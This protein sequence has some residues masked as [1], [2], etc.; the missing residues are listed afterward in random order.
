M[1]TSDV[2]KRQKDEEPR[3]IYI[4]KGRGI[5]FSFS[6]EGLYDRE[7]EEANAFERARRIDCLLFKASYN[8]KPRLVIEPGVYADASN[9]K[10]IVNWLARTYP[11]MLESDP[12]IPGI[13]ISSY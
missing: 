2:F 7:T 1:P 9:N 5:N 11:E 6:Y 12:C 8:K 13:Q 4:I 3:P 10:Y